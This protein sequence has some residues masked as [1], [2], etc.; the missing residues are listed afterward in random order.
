MANSH[1]MTI[2]LLVAA[3]LTA[4]GMTLLTAGCA[5]SEEAPT[6]TKGSQYVGSGTSAADK[7]AEQRGGAHRRL[8]AGGAAQSQ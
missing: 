8:P 4:F 5:K 6:N 2:K 7:I 1:R 3:V